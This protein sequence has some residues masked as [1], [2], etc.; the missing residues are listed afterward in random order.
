MSLGEKVN[1]Y[2]S[3]LNPLNIDKLLLSVSDKVI[4]SLYD[5]NK[6]TGNT[7]AKYCHMGAAAAGAAFSAISLS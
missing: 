6:I 7:A 1:K 5:K 4:N 3:K 2:L